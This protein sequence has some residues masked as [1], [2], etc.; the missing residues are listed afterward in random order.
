MIRQ[1]LYFICIIILLG[2]KSPGD[3]CTYYDN[4]SVGNKWVEEFYDPSGQLVQKYV[5]SISKIEETDTGKTIEISSTV[6]NKKGKK[7]YDSNYK[8]WI[9]DGFVHIDPS[10]YFKGMEVEGDL[11]LK[12]PCDPQ[13]GDKLDGYDLTTTVTSWRI[14]GTSQ[15]MITHI[16]MSDINFTKSEDVK[17]PTGTYQC[18]QQTAIVKIDKSAMQISTWYSK[19]LGPIK[20]EMRD[21][22]GNLLSY[23]VVTEFTN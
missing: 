10:G 21:A 20:T 4:L 8:M 11:D 22:K 17:T 19:E 7:I 16:Q 1:I 15:S 6:L 12:I 18:V 3:I 23:S 9:Q 5:N 2:F 14:D 13:P